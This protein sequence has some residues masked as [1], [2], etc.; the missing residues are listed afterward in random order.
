MIVSP[1]VLRNDKSL[2]INGGHAP[3][4]LPV[5]DT[6]ICAEAAE[7]VVEVIKSK[8]TSYWGGGPQSKKLEQ[9]VAQMLGREGAFFHNSGSAALVTGLYAL[10]ANEN[11]NV[12]ISSSGF[13][14]SI[15]AV[16]HM[17]SRPIFLPTDKDTL[18]CQADVS[19]WVQEPID[20]A[21]VTQFFGNVV[22]IDAIMASTKAQLLL[23]DGS[24]AFGSKLNGEYVGARGDVAT[25]AG[26]NRKLL[27]A[28][29]GGI[30]VYDKA[31]YGVNMRKIGHH[32]KGSTQFGEVP[33]FNF[34]GGE[35]EATLALTALDFFEEKAL[36]RNVSA[37]A[38]SN[39]VQA[40]GLK[41]AQPPAHL[42]CHVVWFD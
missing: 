7:A 26:S 4:R 25:F 12:A 3:L 36:S 23:E 24:Q 19:Q 2:S 15:N 1:D 32:G 37:A 11:T 33:G 29:Q 30:N 40:A 31:E 5:E 28:G 21:L 14:S 10:G 27:G 9:R 41:V 38:F 8:H 34:R 16:Y 17:K 35:I 6:G 18:V 39:V 13:V 22:D 42:D 20:I